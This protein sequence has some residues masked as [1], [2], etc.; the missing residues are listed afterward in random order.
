MTSYF[1][2]STIQ[3]PYHSL[4][5]SWWPG[6]YL[7]LSSMT[8][9]YIGL[10]LNSQSFCHTS[11]LKIQLTSDSV[12]LY[13][14]S[15]W[16]GLYFPAHFQ[17]F[18]WLASS[19]PSNLCSNIAFSQRNFSN[20]LVKISLFY[21]LGAGAAQAKMLTYKF[22]CGFLVWW[23]RGEGGVMRDWTGLVRGQIV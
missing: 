13:L 6:P 12:S 1:T 11:C 23:T 9:S 21:L 18:R 19:C 4:Q 10:P 3:A 14:L 5:V 22:L 17:I 15:S 7:T 2:Y 16:N 20:H 8:L